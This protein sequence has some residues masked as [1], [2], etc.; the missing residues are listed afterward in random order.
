ME[1]MKTL[2]DIASL[3]VGVIANG[4]ATGASLFHVLKKCSGIRKL[5]LELSSPDLE[6]K[7]SFLYT[8]CNCASW[9]TYKC[10]F[11]LYRLGCKYVLTFLYYHQPR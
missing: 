4:H 6:V 8:I 1:D 3:V 2:P 10:L 5:A 7:L 9:F 11:Y